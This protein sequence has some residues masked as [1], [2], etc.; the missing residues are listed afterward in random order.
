ML[1]V[2]LAAV[3]ATAV[4]GASLPAV[5]DAR[6]DRTAT[7]LDASIA[8]VSAAGS[9]LAVGNDAPSTAVAPT[10]T[11]AFSLPQPTWTAAAVEY[12]AVGGSP[13]GPGNRS[14]VTYA[15]E[16]GGEVRRLLSVPVPV[17]TPR[18]PVVFRGRGERT[19]SLSLRATADGPVL[20]V[21]R[22]GRT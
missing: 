4:L 18:G 20:V 1:R 14:A 11:V 10:R 17:R 5:E 16:G 6:A 15:T 7:A 2:V 21:G 22:G 13:G 3:L 19:I 9:A 8:R 12:V